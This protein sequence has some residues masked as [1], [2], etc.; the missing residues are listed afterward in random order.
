MSFDKRP[1]AELVRDT[2]AS[3][4]HL[5]NIEAVLREVKNLLLKSDNDIANLIGGTA[6][7]T[8]NTVR[9]HL[10]DAA[11]EL[12]GAIELLSKARKDCDGAYGAYLR[13]KNQ[14]PRYAR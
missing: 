14:Y 4:E 13:H 8:D 5:K 2:Y 6:H 9:G 3:I 7:D 1:D 10:Q 11:K 12:K